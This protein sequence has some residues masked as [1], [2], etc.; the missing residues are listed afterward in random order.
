[1]QNYDLS[2]EFDFE[3]ANDNH[4]PDPTQRRVP[5]FVTEGQTDVLLAAAGFDPN[6]IPR[7]LHVGA[8]RVAWCMEQ[9]LFNDGAV[10]RA[11]GLHGKKLARTIAA[12]RAAAQPGRRVA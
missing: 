5:R 9:G 7:R 1:M 2:E 12:M 6:K 10:G 11:A 8:L 3:P 4:R